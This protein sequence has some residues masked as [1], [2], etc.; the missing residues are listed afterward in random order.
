[1]EENQCPVYGYLD[2]QIPAFFCFL[3]EFITFH[4]FLSLIIRVFGLSVTK[5]TEMMINCTLAVLQSRT[6]K[7]ARSAGV[8][9][10]GTMQIRA[11]RP[12]LGD[13]HCDSL[14]SRQLLCTGPDLQPRGGKEEKKNKKR[15][16]RE[17]NGTG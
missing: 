14:S 16:D 2:I 11:I 3:G 13:Q 7:L 10:E 9:A 5:E 1:M 15:A 4:Y 8:L 17:K 6:M 12:V